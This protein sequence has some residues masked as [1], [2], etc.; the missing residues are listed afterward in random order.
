MSALSQLAATLLA[1]CAV[2]GRPQPGT[3]GGKHNEDLDGI[4]ADLE[5]FLKHRDQTNTNLRETQNVY[6]N[7]RNT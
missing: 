2:D 4:G 6:S 7:N 5:D 1:W 3:T